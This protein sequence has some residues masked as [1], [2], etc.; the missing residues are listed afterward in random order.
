MLVL[1]LSISNIIEIE[2]VLVLRL[3]IGVS[4]EVEY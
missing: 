3:S 4:I 1:K 2:H